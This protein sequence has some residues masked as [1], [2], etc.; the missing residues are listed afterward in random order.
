MSQTTDP[1]FEVKQQILSMVKGF[2]VHTEDVSITVS[3]EN[4]EKGEYTQI[5][6]KVADSDIARTVGRHGVTADALRRIA[7]LTA[8]KSG[9]KKMIFLRVDAPNMPEGRNV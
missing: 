3:E 7:I 8:I 1:L 9:Y 5:S 2:V 4:D 6:I